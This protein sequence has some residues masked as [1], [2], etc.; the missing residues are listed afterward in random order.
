MENLYCFGYAALSNLTSKS[1]ASI[2][3]VILVSGTI[4][5]HSFGQS[6]DTC[7]LASA[8]TS[9]SFNP[10]LNNYP[11]QDDKITVVVNQETTPWTLLTVH[12]TV[13]ENDV[14]VV[15]IN[16]A[17][18]VQ[19][20]ITVTGQPDAVSIPDPNNG[21]WIVDVRGNSI[22]PSTGSVQITIDGTLESPP[23]VTPPGFPWWEVAVAAVIVGVVI[24]ATI[25][26]WPRKKEE[27]QLPPLATV[28][29]VARTNSSASI[30]SSETKVLQ[31][32]TLPYYAGLQ[33]PNGQIM[34]ISGMSKDFGRSDFEPYVSRDVLNLISRRHFQITFSVK[35]KSFLI[36]DLGSSNGT[37]LNGNE[38]KG[39]G[40]VILKDG[41]I[42]SPSNILNLKFK[43]S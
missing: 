4:S 38:I 21:N 12:V 19:K 26:L 34:A 10:N 36:E 13:Q 8:S 17:S 37:M 32:G 22:T 5:I 14:I 43:G 40:K 29:P 39:K 2:L 35:E 11:S 23:S 25:A 28:S 30:M 9:C 24:I 3:L 33:L 42:I 15:A 6:A 16:N 27:R 41:D 31:S 20:T 7:N 1:L 18:G